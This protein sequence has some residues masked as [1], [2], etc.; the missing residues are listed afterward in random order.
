MFCEPL[1]L[2]FSVRSL[3]AKLQFIAC[4][5]KEKLQAIMALMKALKHLCS[6]SGAEDVEWWLDRF[7]VAIE[8]D[9]EEVNEMNVLIMKLEGS[10]YDMWRGLPVEQRSTSEHIKAALWVTF[11]KSQFEAWAE[12][13]RDSPA[14]GE[15]LVVFG[16][17]LRTHAAVALAGSNPVDTVCALFLLEALPTVLRDKVVLHLGEDITVADVVKTAT[18][19]KS[20]PAARVAVKVDEVAEEEVAAAAVAPVA[21]P[22]GSV[23]PCFRKAPQVVPQSQAWTMLLCVWQFGASASGLPS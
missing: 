8:I 3:L 23:G 19:V 18:L 17:R 14:P 10:A 20:A 15:S 1:A 2:A 16:K 21:K 11:G 22:H 13:V 4:F 7:E 6:F 12:M 5:S 9:K